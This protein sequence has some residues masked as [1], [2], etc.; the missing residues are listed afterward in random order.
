MASAVVVGLGVDV[1]PS[2]VRVM[3][4]LMVLLLASRAI[5]DLVRRLFGGAAE[6][7]PSV[8]IFEATTSRR[9]SPAAGYVL[10][11]LV[12]LFLLVLEGHLQHLC[13]RGDLTARDIW[14]V[15]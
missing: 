8:G 10:G 2:S 3:I 5:Y 12:M 15:C 1:N 7:R 4:L 13:A 11:L 6:K 9:T 14:C